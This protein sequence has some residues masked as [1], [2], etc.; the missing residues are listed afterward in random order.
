[1]T[2]AEPLQVIA[3]DGSVNGYKLD[4]SNARV[5]FW[6]SNQL[7]DGWLALL[8]LLLVLALTGKFFR[9]QNKFHKR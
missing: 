6:G 4:L 7:I 8:T 9:A 2:I 5:W 3:A 1:M